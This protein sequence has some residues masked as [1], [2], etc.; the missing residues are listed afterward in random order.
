LLPD[1][2]LL[3]SDS[4]SNAG[5]Y[6][7]AKVRKL[8]VYENQGEWLIC[9]LSVSNLGATQA[10]V[11]KFRHGCLSGNPLSNLALAPNMFEVTRL[12]G[13]K[14]RYI[15]GRDGEHVRAYGNPDASFLIAGQVN[16]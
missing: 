5:V 4:R 8:A 11:A 16:G 14:L 6:Q 13:K 3:T 15:L 10:V 1:G 2:L 9:I 7:G 12:V